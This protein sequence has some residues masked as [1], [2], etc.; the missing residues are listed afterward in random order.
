MDFDRHC[1]EIVRQTE[2][3]VRDVGG[4]DLAVPVPSCP[5]WSL[6]DLLRH[7]GGGQRW[8]EEVVRTRATGPLPDDHFR[9]VGGDDSGPVPARWLLS[10]ARALAATLRAAG[11]E[12][13]LWAPFTYDRTAFWARRFTHETALHRAD[14]TLAARV[15]Y[16]VD[17]AV[18][19]DA[20][21]EWLELDCIEW[22]FE[23]RPAK[24]DLLG[25]GSL[26]LVA[27]G[28]SWL[29]DLT[30]PV[31]TWRRGAGPASVTVRGSLAGLLL[32]LYRRAPV[33][34]VSVDGER[35]LLADYLEQAAFS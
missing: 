29:V 4:A 30:G 15:P 8:A 35:A 31:I 32:V 23:R 2:T 13:K 3:L 19:V 10:G 16:T 20:I 14:A 11:P 26:A 24:R 1:D 22:H 21:D 17:D 7:I 33:S 25:R 5:T 12:E 28:E 18:A 9:T 34:S 6:G 27:P